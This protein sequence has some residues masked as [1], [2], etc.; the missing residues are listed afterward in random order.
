MN[1]SILRL[2]LALMASLTL[3]ACRS[4]PPAARLAPKAGDADYPTQARSRRHDQKVAQVKAGHYDLALIGDSITHT[5]GDMPGSVYEPLKAVWDR[6]FAPRHAINLGH[7]GFRTENILWNLENGELDFSPSPKVVVLLIGTNNTDDRNFR[8]VHSASQI[9]DGTRAIVELIRSRHPTTKIL[10]LRVFPRGG[11]DEHGYAERVFHGS[12]QCVETC[13]K[14]GLLTSKLA[15][16]N[17]VFWLDINRTFLRRDGTINTDLMPDLLHPNLP[18]GEAWAQAIE[19]T[20]A[21]LM[22]DQPILDTPR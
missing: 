13:R 2:G 12:K 20:L 14:A 8:H 11:D 22:G 5:M 9:F 16:G 17:H 1:S 7:N 6:H 21:R 19:P 15:D 4:T 10:I 18:G 3:I